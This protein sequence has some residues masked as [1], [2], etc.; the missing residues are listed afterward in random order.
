MAGNT[1]ENTSRTKNMVTGFSIGPMAE[2]TQVLSM[3]VNSMAMGYIKTS[4]GKN[5][6]DT[7]YTVKVCLISLVMMNY[8]NIALKL[9]QTNKSIVNYYNKS[10]YKY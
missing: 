8:E 10:I 6:I 4:M 9:I 7:G 5:S 3:K 2:A 1:K